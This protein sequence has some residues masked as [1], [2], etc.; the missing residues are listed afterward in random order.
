MQVQSLGGA[1]LWVIFH[2][3]SSLATEHA[4]IVRVCL[5]E[6]GS[7]Q[8]VPSWIHTTGESFAFSHFTSFAC[9]NCSN[10]IPGGVCFLLIGL[11]WEF[12]TGY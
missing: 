6:L 9:T 4:H 2:G 8:A 10:P 12:A 1:G 5:L 7:K 3:Q 11:C